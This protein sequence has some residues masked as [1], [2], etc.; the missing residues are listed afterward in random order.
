MPKSISGNERCFKYVKC[1]PV[2]AQAGQAYV[3]KRS[4][5]FS[6]LKSPVVRFKTSNL[7]SSGLVAN[8]Q[9]SRKAEPQVFCLHI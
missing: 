4:S 1:C 3:W 2:L 5:Q 7:Q 9:S 8:F 6:T